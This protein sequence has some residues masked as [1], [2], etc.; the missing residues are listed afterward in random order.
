MIGGV[1]R[2]DRGGATVQVA[3]IE[4][5]PPKPAPAASASGGG[6]TAGVAGGEGSGGG[7]D[8]NAERKQELDELLDE[9]E[10]A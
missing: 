5:A 7:Y 3:F 8:P 6:S 10:V 1:M 4:Y 9:A 2:D